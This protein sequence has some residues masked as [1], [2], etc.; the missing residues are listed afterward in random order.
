V[1]AIRTDK[2]IAFG[3]ATVLELDPY[4][5]ASTDCPNDAG[6]AADPVGRKA[7]KQTVEQNSARD[8]PNGSAQ[9]VHDRGNVDID[10]PTTG[11]RRNPHG[12]QQLTRPVHIDAKLI[13]DRRAVGP[14]GHRTATGPHI[15]PPFEDRHIMSVS[16]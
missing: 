15:R 9:A 2:Q 8:H 3:R 4:P 1:Q 14:D 13:Q 10:Q 5:I 12:G 6:I 16:E 11:R 7:C